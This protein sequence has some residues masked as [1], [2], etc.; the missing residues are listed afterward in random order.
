MGDRMGIFD[1]LP[2]EKQERIVNAALAAFASN[3]YKKTSMADIAAAAGISKAS[4]FHYFGSKR[5]L[6]LHLI[7]VCA[8]SLRRGMGK[9]FDAGIADFFEKLRY[10]AAIKAEVLKCRPYTFAFLN[11]MYF[12]TDPEVRT[13]IRALVEESEKTSRQITLEGVDTGKFKEGV[14]PAAVFRILILIE[15]GVMSEMTSLRYVDI[16]RVTE[17]FY[18]YLNLFKRHFYREEYL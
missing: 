4:L 1:S 17:D 5:E 18:G 6:Y 15:E 10:A 14:D 7:D 9:W 3:G 13:Y 12:E 2:K 11:S 8:D 16:D